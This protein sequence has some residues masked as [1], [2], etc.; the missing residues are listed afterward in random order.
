MLRRVGFLAIALALTSGWAQADSAT[1]LTG[2]VSVDEA[3]TTQIKRDPPQQAAHLGLAVEA[4]NGKLRVVDVEPG[5]PADRI[6]MLPND[7][8]ISVDGTKVADRDTMRRLLQDKRPGQSVTLA[9]E[10]AGKASTE[11]IK[12]AAASNPLKDTTL[13]PPVMGVTLVETGRGMRI[14]SVR[15]GSPAAAAGLKIGD[16][17]QTV[18]G[19]ATPSLQG[20]QKPAVVARSGRQSARGLHPRR[21]T[22]GSRR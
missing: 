3:K 12:L 18:N 10:R 7:L 20:A 13:P 22:N 5:S 17:V 19:G 8:I 16:V 21:S 15:A 1:D 11:K 14:D 2:Y 4:S 9:I 6:G